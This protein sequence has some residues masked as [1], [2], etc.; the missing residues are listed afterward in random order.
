V[1]LAIG[2]ALGAHT[3]FLPFKKSRVIVK[4]GMK[5]I[6]ATPEED[7]NMRMREIGH[8]TDDTSMAI[9]LADSLLANNFE[10]SGMD[11]RTRFLLWWYGGYNNG[12]LAHSVGL[13]GNIHQSFNE[14]IAKQ[15]EAVNMGKRNNSGNGSIMRL[16]PVPIAFHEDVE[17]AMKMAAKQ[18]LST[19]NGKEAEECCR[20]L[21]YL[22]IKLIKYK[23][24]KPKEVLDSI[25][26][27]FKTDCAAVGFMARSEKESEELFKSYPPSMLGF[28]KGVEDRD[29]NWKSESFSYSKTRVEQNSE[30]I[31]SY[32]MDGLAMA[33]HVCY[34]T[35][36]FEEAV[37]MA[38][39]MGGDSDTVG[40]I[41]GQIAGAMYGLTPKVIELY[42]E[43]KDYEEKGIMIRAFKLYKGAGV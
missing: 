8:Y 29:W 26:K 20:F 34:N 18:S 15:T 25:G 38:V 19:H 5:D 16:A 36:S 32:C 43:L 4:T 33:L 24:G 17:K 42:G 35:K 21:T 23:D 1:G 2:D 31:G 30:Y 3:E 22:I 39:N 28:N 40:A 41:V 14:F 13:G 10:Y 12:G 9:C 6:R 7:L 27:E 37:F 11:L